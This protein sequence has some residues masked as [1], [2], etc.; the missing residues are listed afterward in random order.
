M[1]L[2][3]H[4]YGNKT[5]YGITRHAEWYLVIGYHLFVIASSLIGD[6]IVL[7]ASINYRVF[8]LH[9]V[10]TVIIEHI[11]IC[12]LMVLFTLISPTLASLVA[13][14]WIFGDFVGYIT[15][16]ARVYFCLAGVLL[17]SAMTTSKVLLVKYPL[18]FGTKSRNDAHIICSICWIASLMF[19]AIF[20]RP[21]PFCAEGAKR[22][23]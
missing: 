19:P 22:H 5:M 4:E 16:Y 6:T 23:Y 14:K 18:G 9:K 11:A 13:G 8:K 2:L 10:I 15:Y 7:I 12:D 20:S 17:I 1:T 3:H 21:M